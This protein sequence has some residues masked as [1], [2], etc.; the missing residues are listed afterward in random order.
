M[1]DTAA[2]AA[3]YDRKPQQEHQRLKIF[4]LE[5]AI[6]MHAILDC[7]EQIKRA[8]GITRLSVLDLGGGTGRYC[9]IPTRLLSP[10]A[11]RLDHSYRTRQAWTHCYINGHLSS[12][13]GSC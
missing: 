5:Y 4:A 10:V 12:P 1:T 6:S 11:D 3:M 13:N 8:K 7:I 2:V 9:N